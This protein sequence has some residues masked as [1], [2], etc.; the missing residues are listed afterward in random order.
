MCEFNTDWMPPAHPL[1][2]NELS[3]QA[4]VLNLESNQQPL[5]NLRLHRTTLNQV[6]H[7]RQGPLY[8]STLLYFF[9]IILPRTDFIYISTFFI[10]Q[11]LPLEYKLCDDM[12]PVLLILQTQKQVLRD[13][14][15]VGDKTR[16][17]LHKHGVN[18]L[19]IYGMHHSSR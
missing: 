2:G 18:N 14:E 3:T 11:L 8:P 9:L 19:K 6:S 17:H 5:S 16:H 12:V 7:T 1:P 10:A 15:L 13:T 4:R